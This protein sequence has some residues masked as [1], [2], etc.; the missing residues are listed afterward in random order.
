MEQVYMKRHTLLASDSSRGFAYIS[1][2]TVILLVSSLDVDRKSNSTVQ[3]QE[4]LISYEWQEGWNLEPYI[5]REL[6]PTMATYTQLPPTPTATPTEPGTPRL[7]SLLPIDLTL[8]SSGDLYIADS[9]RDEVLKLGISG[10]LVHEI[11]AESLGPDLGPE[12]CSARHFLAGV[13]ADS[14]IVEDEV[15]EKLHILWTCNWYEK[16]GPR[17]DSIRD[18]HSVLETILLDPSEARSIDRLFDPVGT[19]SSPP[20]VDPQSG[21][22]IYVG[23]PDKQPIPPIT[24]YEPHTGIRVRN[25]ELD[26]LG[27]FKIA[28]LSY[29]YFA[30]IREVE[31]DFNQR[32]REVWISRQSSLGSAVQIRSLGLEGLL[33]LAIASNAADEVFVLARPGNESPGSDKSGEPLVL[34]YNLRGELTQSWSSKELGVPHPPDTKCLGS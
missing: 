25:I 4:G 31:D 22:L 19:R 16:S 2:L 11:S 28:G 30:H 29:P 33:P 5:S 9:S 17:A 8:T 7:N 14:R 21:Q 10:D 26:T 3:A 27:R 20:A 13:A 12:N 15:Q 6:A 24:W 18:Y 1:F 23:D 32:I 34:R